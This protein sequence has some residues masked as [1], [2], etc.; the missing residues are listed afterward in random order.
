MSI[1]GQDLGQSG[2]SSFCLHGTSQTDGEALPYTAAWERR[3]LGEVAEFYSGLTYSPDSVIE[4]GGTFVLRSS[5]VTAGEIVDADNVYVKSN[6]VNCNNVKTGDIVVVVRNGSHNLIGKHAQVKKE[7][8]NTVIGAFMT[9][10][11]SSQSEFTN[12]LLDTQQFDV[13]ITKN[14]GATN[15][16]IT[17]GA[18]KQMTFAIPP[19]TAEQTAIGTFFRTLDDA[20]TLQKRK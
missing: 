19:E 1:L 2:E 13:E 14:L 9:G 7:M 12:V 10:I 20:V 3:K 15:N 11:R 18:F 6:V 17:T 16:Q 4:T 8:K 5:N